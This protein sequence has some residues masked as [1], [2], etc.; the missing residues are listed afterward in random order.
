MGRTPPH[1]RPRF[2]GRISARQGEDS[3]RV[4]A[5]DSYH[6]RVPGRWIELDPALPVAE[7]AAAILRKRLKDFLKAISRLSE[8]ADDDAE[9]ARRVHEVRVSA[10]RADLA[11]RA[12]ADLG[13]ARE[14]RRMRRRI[15]R[16]RRAAGAVRDA[17]I[18]LQMLREMLPRAGEPLAPG[19]KALASGVERARTGAAAA[20]VEAVMEHS[21]KSWRRAIRAL[22]GSMTDV[23]GV[24][25]AGLGR[26]VLA[27]H[28][29]SVLAASH[30]DLNDLANLHQLRLDLKA[31]RYAVE[32]FLPAT[33]PDLQARL[34]PSLE[35][36][37]QVLGD[38]N[39]AG[40]LADRVAA[41]A[42]EQSHPPEVAA[43]IAALAGRVES[44]MMRRRSAA[45]A[46]WETADIRVLVAPLAPLPRPEPDAPGHTRPHERN[47]VE[48]VEPPAEQRGLWLSGEK[49]AVI[50]I[51]SNSIRLLAVELLDR[52]S[53]RVLAEERAMTRLAHGMTQ[54]RHLSPEAMA[55]SVEAIT[56][57][58]A[59]AE[60]LGVT[61]VRAFATAAVREAENADDFASLVHDRAGLTVEIVSDLDE[62][63]LTHRSVA[64][65]IDLSGGTAAVVDL[66]GGSM[67]VVYS[68]QGVITGSVSMP[69]GAVRVTE[70]FGGA[71]ACSGERFGEMRRHVERVI[72]RGVDRREVP[73]AMLV[74]CGGT[75]TTILTLAAAARGVLI[76]RN[77]PA[78]RTLG[79]VSRP[80]LA[81]LTEQ[82]RALT[83]EQRLRVPGLPSDR[84][85]IIVAGLVAVDRLMKRLGVSHVRVHPGGFREGLMLRMI[86]DASAP[87]ERS[88]AAALRE[89]RAFAAR[90]RYP[91]PHSEHVARLALSLYDRLLARHAPVPGL[92]S[93]PGERTLLEAGAIL[94]DVGCLVEYRRH[95]KH[96]YTMVVHADL[97]ALTA[98]EQNLVALLVRYHRRAD[99]SP[100][101][102]EFA[103]LSEAD[104][105]LVT[106]LAAIL[107]LAD[108]LDRDHTQCVRD[109]S[110][111]WAG[112]RLV[113]Q[114]A[115]EGDLS[116]NIGAAGE[117]ASLLR[118]VVAGEVTIV[119]RESPEPS[120]PSQ[121]A[122][123][124]SVQVPVRPAETGVARSDA[125]PHAT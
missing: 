93:D 76:E 7:A 120:S 35:R 87:E 95:H 42:R 19:I 70:A 92:G 97:P 14:A 31:L 16:V 15:R 29:D 48:P 113:V 9:G 100:A 117:K 22:V 49:F 99:P 112:Q 72:R 96:G 85:D 44:L 2:H 124:R 110:P 17:D 50:D 60:K 38:V 65:A 111:A 45:L 64:R 39:D 41:A 53:W 23:P 67:E 107:R 52:R 118:E 69:L 108:G 58:R 37:Q 36:A 82:L 4:R 125:G 21:P 77:S 11:V 27:R 32:I 30:A 83:L 74:G 90:A 102:D 62:G 106:R 121:A 28:A 55:G 115:G 101:H 56:R 109:A 25:L 1:R 116:V 3:A 86:D 5:G 98:R 104:R 105:A 6:S 26:L 73:P 81:H 20:L 75:F 63:R 24:D 114:V 40:R 91:R 46:W 94:H 79:P 34:Y 68:D 43:S 57:F 33:R 78:L 51:G 88:S 71:D 8:G 80:Q 103:V 123:P 10:R 18:Q 59:L 84:A 122:A 61:R 12:F 47:G 119:A 89:A 66:G 13:S 54:T